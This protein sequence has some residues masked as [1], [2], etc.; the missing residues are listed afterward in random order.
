MDIFISALLYSF[1]ILSLT[2][3]SGPLLYF[4]C[5][6]CG[7]KDIKFDRCM[8]AMF[9]A[10]A[11]MAIFG[12]I[13]GFALRDV[14]YYVTCTAFLAF[15][16]VAAR[17]AVST[18]LGIS[19]FTRLSL[20]SLIPIIA[21]LIV[22][23]FVFFVLPGLSG[24]PIRHG[25]WDLAFNKPTLN[26]ITIAISG[27]FLFLGTMVARIPEINYKECLGIMLIAFALGYSFEYIAELFDMPL[28]SIVEEW[29]F[30]LLAFS[31]GLL[32]ALLVMLPKKD[33]KKLAIACLFGFIPALIIRIL[34]EF[35]R[36][37]YVVY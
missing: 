15:S 12:V 31:Q 36:F 7:I 2:F 33:I 29:L 35:I 20:A 37:G 16:Y 4:F 14:P 19:D 11:A 34:V 28:P 9:S 26:V 8:L 18:F 23:T 21:P 1:V 17:I 22:G 10:L 32:F 27:G 24:Y 5:K 6:I 30:P 25:F 13:L 3:I